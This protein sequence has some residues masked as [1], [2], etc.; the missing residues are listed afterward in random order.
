MI[1]LK[2]PTFW[3]RFGMAIFAALIIIRPTLQPETVNREASNLNIWFVVDATG[4]M[5]ARD[6]ENGSKRRFEKV[7]E[8]ITNIVHSV[9]GA[10]Y[11]LIAQDFNTY[12]AMPLSYNADAI[13]AAEPNLMPK[14]SLYAQATSLKQMLAYATKRI[15]SYYAKN[16]DRINA[17]VIMSDGEDVSDENL[18]LA[19]MVSPYINYAAVLGY[20]STEGS[21]IEEILSPYRYDE[22]PS[23]ISDEYVRYYGNNVNVTVDGEHRVISKLNEKNLNEMASLT[24]GQYYHRENGDVPGEIINSL[25][26]A[27]QIVKEKKT[28]NTTSRG[29]IYYIFAM[30]LLLL[31]LWEGEELIVRLLSEKENKNA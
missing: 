25:K 30:G 3:R 31:I 13:I 20:G 27:S 29:E 2:S 10:K 9:P 8:D 11:A 6:V 12:D 19:G 5:V 14:Y 23:L 1:F 15:S 7:Q 26:N 28:E 21:L 18:A 17:L 24:K 4:S 16:P 22:N